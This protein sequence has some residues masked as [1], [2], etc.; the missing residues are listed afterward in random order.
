[1]IYELLT[2]KRADPFESALHPY[3]INNYLVILHK[4]IASSLYNA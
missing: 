3:H 4:V 1:M 2:K